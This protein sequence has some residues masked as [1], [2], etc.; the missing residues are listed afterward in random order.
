M[1]AVVEKTLRIVFASFDEEYFGHICFAV[2][3]KM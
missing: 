2:G 3:L 1:K